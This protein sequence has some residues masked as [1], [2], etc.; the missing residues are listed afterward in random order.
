MYLFQNQQN[1]NFIRKAGAGPSLQLWLG[2]DKGQLQC[3]LVHIHVH[4]LPGNQV[5]LQWWW[6]QAGVS[7]SSCDYE[8]PADTRGYAGIVVV[9]DVNWI[10]TNTEGT[11]LPEDWSQCLHVLKQNYFSLAPFLS[12]VIL[13]ALHM[14]CFMYIGF[15]SRRCISD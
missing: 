12:E 8:L 4:P 10:V 14:L 5:I 7:H 15:F 1:F 6:S 9:V 13:K 2:V 11:A 3:P